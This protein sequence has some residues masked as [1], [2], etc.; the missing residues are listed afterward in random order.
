M[1]KEI[2]WDAPPLTPED[3][4]LITAYQRAGRPLDDLAYT[5][6]FERLCLEVGANQ[7]RQDRHQVFKRLLT[8]RKSGRLP[9][10]YPPI[11]IPS[12]MRKRNRVPPISLPPRKATR[13]SGQSG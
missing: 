7:S 5:E 10:L 1:S 2:E 12:A 11:Q 8:L 13:G 3:E 4:R 6:E 9:S